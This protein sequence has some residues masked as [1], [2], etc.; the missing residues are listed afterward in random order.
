[1][2]TSGIVKIDGVNAKRSRRDN[3]SI[4]NSKDFIIIAKSIPRSW[5]KNGYGCEKEGYFFT[6]YSSADES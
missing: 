3:V 5:E 1:M 4:I 2:D 6:F